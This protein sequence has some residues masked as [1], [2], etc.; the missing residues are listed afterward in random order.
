MCFFQTMFNLRA[1][2]RKS[3]DLFVLNSD[4][5]HSRRKETE[6]YKATDTLSYS[7]RLKARFN[8]LNLLQLD[9]ENM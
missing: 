2:E 9:Q 4:I 1:K 7:E 8:T 5:F 6:T 3:K